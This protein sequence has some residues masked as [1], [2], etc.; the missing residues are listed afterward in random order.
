MRL[1]EKFSKNDGVLFYRRFV[2]SMV[3]GVADNWIVGFLGSIS[4]G[5][6]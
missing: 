1:N 4:C 6:V 2:N 3:R 5:H